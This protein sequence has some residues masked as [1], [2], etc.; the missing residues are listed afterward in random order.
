MSFHLKIISYVSFP[1]SFTMTAI[2]LCPLHIHWHRFIVTVWDSNNKRGLIFCLLYS[3]TKRG[4]R[5]TMEWTSESGSCCSRF[6]P[7]CSFFVIKMES[8]RQPSNDCR[9]L[10]MHCCLFKQLRFFFYFKLVSFLIDGFL[11]HTEYKCI[12]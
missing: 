6:F 7:F 8:L 9:W 3:F 12:L 2:V 1:T 5:I 11:L 4:F 10:I